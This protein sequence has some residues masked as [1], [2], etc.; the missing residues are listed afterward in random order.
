M[1]TGFLQFHALV[2]LCTGKIDNLEILLHKG[3]YLTL[4]FMNIHAK[5][6]PSMNNYIIN[7]LSRLYIEQRNYLSGPLV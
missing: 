2:H 4:S 7:K 5:L 1:I 3:T 6:H